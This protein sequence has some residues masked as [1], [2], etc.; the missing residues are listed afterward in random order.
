MLKKFFSAVLI[1]IALQ[2]MAQESSLLGNS[3][4][5]Q[6]P[7]LEKVKQEVQNGNSP[8][9]SNS[10]AFDP[11]TL[12]INSNADLEVIKYLLSFEG[13]PVDKKTHHSRSYLHWAAAKGNLEVVKYLVSIGSDVHF[14][15][16]YGTPITAYAA[17]SGNLNTQ[18]Y[19]FLFE[20]GV[21]IQGKYEN[22]SNLILL[23]AP[24]DTDFSLAKYFVSKGLKWDSQDDNGA[25]V[26]DYTARTG[27]QELLNNLIKEGI[28]PTSQA[29]FFAAQGGRGR[30]NPFE[31]YQYLVDDLKL[32]PKAVR[33]SDKNTVLHVLARNASPEIVYYFLNKGLDVN[34]I[35]AEGNTVLHVAVQ[36]RNAEVLQAVLSKTQNLDVKNQFGQTPLMLAVRALNADAVETLLGKG[37]NIQ[38]L[39]LND[40][41]LISYAFQAYNGNNQEPFNQVLELLESNGLSVKSAQEDGTNAFH[42]AI[43][44]LNP[45]L[46]EVAKKYNADINQQDSEG[47]TPLHKAALIA[48]DDQILKLLIQLG[49]D[50]SIKNEW[51]ESVF[52][53]ASDNER[54]KEKNVDVS[55]LK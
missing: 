27:N 21:D 33:N 51:E 37:S 42:W 24:H 4:W 41:N 28:K 43:Q 50:T 36:N 3:F 7:T 18:V 14:K 5:A 39:D 10:R 6:N 26:F 9:E 11:V 46:I 31:F 20:N 55:F 54:L 22:G 25:T 38:A 45:Y 2:G 53:L 17:S 23:S 30:Q 34:L 19:D 47:M 48:E 8:T 40:Q 32:D 1:C 15:D 29:L 49:A 44:N 13:N 12:A 16:S 35:N 52:D